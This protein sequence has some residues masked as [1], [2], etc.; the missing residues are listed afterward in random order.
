M[1]T[2]VKHA[3][4]IVLEILFTYLGRKDDRVGNISLRKRC[5]RKRKKNEKGQIKSQP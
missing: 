5:M 4:I 3:A 2:Q 1:M